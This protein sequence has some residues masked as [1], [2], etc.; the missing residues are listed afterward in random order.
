VP[1][2]IKGSRRAWPD[3]TLL[4][5][6][7]PLEIVVGPPLC[8]QGRDWTDIV[9]LRD[10]ARD[11]LAQQTGEQAFQDHTPESLARVSAVPAPDA[12]RH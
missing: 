8:P 2:A 6:R 5:R 3:E 7:V 10:R 11:F 1:I 9:R 12:R 4:L